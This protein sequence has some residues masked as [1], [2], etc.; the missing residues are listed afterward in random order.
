MPTGAFDAHPNFGLIDVFGTPK[1]S[2]RAFQLLHMA[3]DTR[4][5]VKQDGPGGA[6]GE[7]LTSLALK[8]G[9]HY[10]LFVVNTGP[11]P[12]ENAG[13]ADNVTDCDVVVSLPTEATLT[14]IDKAH[15]NPKAAWQEMGSPAYPSAPQLAK[16]QAASELTF[17][18]V[19]KGSLSTTVPARGTLALSG[20]LPAIPSSE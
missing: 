11:L 10:A 19:P 2:Y 17:E 20:L 6:C 8:N 7:T 18:K 15:A 4:L 16:L 1:P 3:G 13:W 5:Q 9:T 14:R 12:L